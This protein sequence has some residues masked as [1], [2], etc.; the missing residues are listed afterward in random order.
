MPI[1]PIE[2]RNVILPKKFRGYDPTDVHA[3]LSEVADEFEKLLESNRA[4]GNQVRQLEDKLK[5]LESLEESIKQTLLMAQQTAE[6][7]QRA[8]DRSMELQL[9][10]T[11]AACAEIKSRHLK[12]LET[13]KFDL[14][15]LRMQRVRFVAE[16]RSL[17]EMHLRLL[18]D[19]AD[20]QGELKP[21]PE[22][23]PEFL[24]LNAGSADD[25]TV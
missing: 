21:H 23:E 22:T 14:A 5:Q 11:E 8:V 18:Q 19:R 12:E 7:K 20:Q 2:L 13:L 3:L 10:E 16:L 1:N 24:A 25:S 4:L 15:S 17:L 9:R 6:E